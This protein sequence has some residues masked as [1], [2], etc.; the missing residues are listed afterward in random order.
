MH[1]IGLR[2]GRG[3]PLGKGNC[4]KGPETLKRVMM[5]WNTGIRKQR[6]SLGHTK[7]EGSGNTQKIP[8]QLLEAEGIKLVVRRE[9]LLQEG[10]TEAVHLANYQVEGWKMN[11]HMR[12]RG[13]DKQR[14][15]GC[16]LSVLGIPR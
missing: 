15:L 8:R 16:A 5:K 12:Y 1:R 7:E 13:L 11:G 9:G 6:V 2:R 4:S 14:I 3:H 10:D